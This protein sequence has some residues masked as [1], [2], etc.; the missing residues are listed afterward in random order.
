MI[1]FD[2]IP[3]TRMGPAANMDGQFGG[4]NQCGEP[5][6]ALV[7]DQFETMIANYPVDE[8]DALIARIRADDDSVHRSAILELIL[9]EWVIKQDHTVLALEPELDHTSKRPDFLVAAPDG[10]QYVL[11][12]T[13]RKEDDDHLAGIKDGIDAI[14]SPVYLDV[15]ITGQP[16]QTLSVRRVTGKISAFIADIDLSRDRRDWDVLAWEE[17][18]ARFRIKP[19]SLKSEKNKHARTIGMYS[20]GAG[21]VASTGDLERVLKTKAGRYGRLDMPYIVATTSHDFTTGLYEVTTS[22]FGTEA[23]AFNP[24]NPADP[25]RLIRNA[26]G[27]WRGRPDQWTNTGL[28]G[29]LHIPSLSMTMMAR[30]KPLLMLHPEPRHAF[31]GKWLNADTHAFVDDHIQ[32]VDEGVSLGSI[33]GLPDNWPE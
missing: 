31:D 18:G 14:E 22:L 4:I 15:S 11:E 23:V 19:F 5:Y 25:G 9:H 1:L 7:R 21:I 32:K 13:A 3:R 30:R 10:S 6:A 28:S 29:V 12:A 20:S 24:N 8:R 17:H 33:L 2:D 27:I 26:D 16:T